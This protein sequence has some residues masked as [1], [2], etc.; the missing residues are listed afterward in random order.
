MTSLPLELPRA[1]APAGS[2][3]RPDLTAEQREAVEQRGGS[4]FVHAGAGSGKTSVLVERF[5]RAVLDDGLAVEQV[6]A[7][8]FTDKAAAELRARVRERFL[9]EGEREHARAAESAWIST[10]HGFCSRLLRAHALAAGVDPEYR[11]LDEHE[12]ERLA[13][14]AF[15]AALEE[16]L[17]RPGDRKPI[18][19]AAAYGADRLE[20]ELRSVHARAR[21]RGEREPRLPQLNPPAA[22]EV[23]AAH[24]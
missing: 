10:I 20:R 4:L 24:K 11:V 17:A 2:A 1:G 21:G 3:G 19:L 13:G 8:T 16:F 7:I 23:T 12:A 22:A 18:E 14:E 9:A 6:L 15:E 5:A